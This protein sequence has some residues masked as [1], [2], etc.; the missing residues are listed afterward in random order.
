MMQV[1]ELQGVVYD[2]AWG[3]K[4]GRAQ[5]VF[6][7]LGSGLIVAGLAG[8]IFTFAPVVS[9]ETR[10]QWYKTFASPQEE[11]RRIAQ[12]FGVPNTQFSIYI[13]K[14]GAKAEVLQNVDPAEP[15]IYMQAL[16]RGVAHAA[17]SVFPGMEGGTYLFAHST[18]A[19]WNVAQ[20][21]AVFYLLRE[22][23]PGDE[24]YIFFL[25]KVYKYGV[26]QKE[27]VDAKDISW[28]VNARQGPERLILQSCWPPGTTWKRLIV[29]A[30]PRE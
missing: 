10:Y 5:K 28:L 29:V 24:I 6:R 15:E 4:S 21:N 20:F 7:Y 30:E 1:V 14:I 11:Q 25:D 8:L 26:T 18:N 19:P 13:P 22:L 16:T 3:L 9:S 2:A 23:E 17:G 27:V 12:E